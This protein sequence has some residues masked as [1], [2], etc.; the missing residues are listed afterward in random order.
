MKIIDKYILKEMIGPF[1]FGVATFTILYISGD[2]IIPV[3]RNIPLHT[4]ASVIGLFFICRL[5][6]VLVFTF[7]MSVLL[8]AL[9]SFGRLSGESEIIAIK[10][11][12]ISF[13]RVVIPGIFLG[14]VIS[15][16]AFFMNDKLAPQSIYISRTLLERAMSKEALRERE[17]ITIQ[18]T[19]DTGIKRI[20][21]AV[22]FDPQT[23]KLHGI[24]IK[25]FRGDR[26]ER[27]VYA[28]DAYWEN[29]TWY[30]ENGHI[31]DFSDDPSMS[32]KLQTDFKN[33]KRDIPGN[34]EEFKDRE[35]YP[36]E[37]SRAQLAQKIAGIKEA[38]EKGSNPSV[39][40]DQTAAKKEI[41]TYSLFY[42]KKASLPFACLVFGIFGMPLGLRP[43]RASTSIG[44]GISIIFILLYYFF[45]ALGDA[46]GSSGSIPPL[47][48]SWL[49]NIVFGAAGV[50]LIIKAS[51]H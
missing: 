1:L 8:S 46:A 26:L 17:N 39:A 6:Y 4:P 31:Y 21:Y 27:L 18:E 36:D 22:R 5:P 30:L 49:P 28:D 19:L 37:M 33:M 12:G 45:M 51:Q 35:R 23:K 2:V 34:P 32:V 42:D 38:V 14:L 41:N 16:A 50:Y 44:L 48:A 11:G 15:L 20:T 25:D 40:G 10:A 13:S 7:P 43:H 9:L 3:S 29:N 47:L 24:T